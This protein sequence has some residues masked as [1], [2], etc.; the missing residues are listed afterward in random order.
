MSHLPLLPSLPLP[1]PLH[2]L[3]L[4]RAL[5]S[6]SGSSHICLKDLVVMTTAIETN[7]ISAS[8]PLSVSSYPIASLL[9]HL[10]CQL[11][12][13]SFTVLLVHDQL[14]HHPDITGLPSSLPP[15]LFSPPSLPPSLFSPPSL[16][17]LPPPG[18][19]L[20]HGPGH[21]SWRTQCSVP[22]SVHISLLQLFSYWHTHLL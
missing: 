3:L 11:S 12:P 18:W 1:S 14:V 21:P 13:P 17:S 19:S 10:F 7:Q 8:P 4:Y 5:N 9:P 2:F 22:M 15:S 6:H 20:C 16:P